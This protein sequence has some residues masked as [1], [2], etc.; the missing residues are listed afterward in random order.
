MLRRLKPAHMSC[1]FGCV[2]AKLRGG[3]QGI[4]A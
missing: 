2:A 1:F 4:G 3:G